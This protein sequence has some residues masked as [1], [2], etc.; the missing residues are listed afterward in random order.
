MKHYL[1]DLAEIGAGQGAPQGDHNYCE[2][3]LPFVKAGNLQELTS[4]GSIHDI[5]KVSDEV[6]KAHKLKLYPRGTV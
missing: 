5:Q 1:R 4:G 2:D 3:G 6:A